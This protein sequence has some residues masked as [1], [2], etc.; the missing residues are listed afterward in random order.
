MLSWQHSSLLNLTDIKEISGPCEAITCVKSICHPIAINVS[1]DSLLLYLWNFLLYLGTLGPTL[2]VPSRPF[3][4]RK[5]LR[6][7]LGSR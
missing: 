6:L 5:T 1:N 7:S 3:G 2:K 4:L